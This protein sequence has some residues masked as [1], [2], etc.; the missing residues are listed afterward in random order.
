VRLLL[1]TLLVLAGYVLRG[2]G[3]GGARAR[4]RG[5]DSFYELIPDVVG[6]K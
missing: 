3:G 6:S 4:G 5:R 1:V 2:R